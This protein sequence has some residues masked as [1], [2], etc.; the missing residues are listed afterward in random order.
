MM[1]QETVPLPVAPDAVSIAAYVEVVFGYCDG[2]VAVRALAEKG[3]NDRPPHQ[4]APVSG[5]VEPT[6]C[7][8]PLRAT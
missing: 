6:S 2:W 5:R 4:L 1:A 3:A 7:V 8:A